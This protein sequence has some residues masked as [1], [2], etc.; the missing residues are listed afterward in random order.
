MRGWFLKCE[1]LYPSASYEL[2]GVQT[3]NGHDNTEDALTTNLAC[4]FL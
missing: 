3:N 2:N 1:A 4:I